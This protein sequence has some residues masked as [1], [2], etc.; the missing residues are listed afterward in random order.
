M[1]G[2]ATVTYKLRVAHNGVVN[3]RVP[4]YD[5][6]KKLSIASRRGGAG[7]CLT[8]VREA[9]SRCLLYGGSDFL[10]RRTRTV[11]HTSDLVVKFISIRSRA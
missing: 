11:P 5:R 7:S 10:T 1:R 6:E 9:I 8:K 3:A 4:Y 2:G